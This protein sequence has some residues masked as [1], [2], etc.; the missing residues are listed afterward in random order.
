MMAFMAETE[1]KDTWKSPSF[2][3]QASLALT[4]LAGFPYYTFK[5]NSWSVLLS[6]WWMF[7]FLSL[8]A[9]GWLFF[10]KWVTITVRN[11]K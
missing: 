2:L 1:N 6:H 8:W 4:V 7:I 3:I 11:S 9:V 10:L 5:N